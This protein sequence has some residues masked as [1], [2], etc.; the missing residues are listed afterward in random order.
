M[1]TQVFAPPTGLG[2]P[3]ARSSMW[4]TRKQDNVSG[5]Q[6]RVAEWSYPKYQWVL[7]ADVLR[8]GVINGTTYAEFANMLG[9]FNNL[10]GGEDS[11]LYTDVD[12]HAVTG[13]LIGTGDG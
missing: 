6:V 1:G 7:Q 2:W 11:F 12:D 10:F 3:V 9:F 13:Q 5:K 8:H 4:Q